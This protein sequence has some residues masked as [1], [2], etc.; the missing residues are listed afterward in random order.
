[1]SE[2]E[3]KIL[4]ARISAALD[5]EQQGDEAHAAYT[6]AGLEPGR[7]LWETYSLIGDALRSDELAQSPSR[8]FTESLTAQLDQEPPL[9]VSFLRQQPRRRWVSGGVAIAAS[10]A[11]AVWYIGPRSALVEIVQTATNWPAA[12]ERFADNAGGSIERASV[13]RDPRLEDYLR[14]HRQYAARQVAPLILV[15]ASGQ[16]D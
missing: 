11:A 5:G 16:D 3:S 6:D 12:Q 9:R 4:A 13:V 7:E 8:R 1:M 15:G 2:T 10:V 14:A